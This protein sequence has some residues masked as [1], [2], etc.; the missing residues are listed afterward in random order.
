[1]DELK[2]FFAEHGDRDTANEVI[3]FFFMRSGVFGLGTQASLPATK[4]K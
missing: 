3:N 1:V 2:E 4:Q